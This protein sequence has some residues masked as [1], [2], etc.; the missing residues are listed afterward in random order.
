ME[1]DIGAINTIT[2]KRSK[3]NE[4]QITM[5][6]EEI[7]EKIHSAAKTENKRIKLQVIIQKVFSGTKETNTEFSNTR[8]IKH[9]EK[10]KD[11]NNY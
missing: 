7:I 4:E 10:M 5:R 3:I 9:L 8:R 6:K 2:F 1:D 11:S